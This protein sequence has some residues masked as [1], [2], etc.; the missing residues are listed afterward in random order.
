MVS[1]HEGRVA[2]VNEGNARASL[3]VSC[4]LAQSARRTETGSDASNCRRRSLLFQNWR[5]KCFRRTT[6][7]GRI[8][9]CPETRPHL[10]DVR[11]LNLTQVPHDESL[12]PSGPKCIIVAYNC[13]CG[14]TFTVWKPITQAEGRH[15]RSPSGGKLG[16][17]TEAAACTG[18]YGLY[19]EF[20]LAV[21]YDEEQRRRYVCG[22]SG[23][24]T[25]AGRMIG[26]MA[27]QVQLPAAR[28]KIANI[29]GAL[30]S[31]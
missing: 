4:F 26:R 2:D 28:E 23:D 5:S 17:T 14:V 18:T 9:R 15:L 22:T 29:D 6:P 3:R 20:K 30:D 13:V 24:H 12:R 11:S 8:R 19:K 1:R 25:Q 21:L 16:I 10:P 27:T 7:G 31:Q